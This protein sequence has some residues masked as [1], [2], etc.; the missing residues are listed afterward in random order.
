MFWE[1]RIT[2]PTSPARI[3]ASRPRSAAVPS[4]PTMIRCP[5]SFAGELG[6]PVAAGTVVVCAVA[7]DRWAPRAH[8]TPPPKASATT[9]HASAE[10]AIPIL[11]WPRNPRPADR[12]LSEASLGYRSALPITSAPWAP[13]WIWYALGVTGGRLEGSRSAPTGGCPTWK[14]GKRLAGESCA[15]RDGRRYGPAGGRWGGALCARGSSRPL[16]PLAIAFGAGRLDG[17]TAAGRQGNCDEARGD[18][19]LR[20]RHAERG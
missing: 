16:C 9:A 7:A 5:S 1:N 6:T 17:D 18:H 13:P 14:L 10:N 11:P 15:A 2:E 4:N 19:E 8:P 12:S 20:G 3:L